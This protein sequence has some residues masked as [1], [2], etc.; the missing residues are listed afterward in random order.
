MIV[1]RG[2]TVRPR[3]VCADYSADFMRTLIQSVR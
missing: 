3:A 2:G 1:I